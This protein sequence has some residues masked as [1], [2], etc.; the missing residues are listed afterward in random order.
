MTRSGEAGEDCPNWVR[1]RYVNWD[2]WDDRDGEESRK[3]RGG[4][5]GMK[6]V[7]DKAYPASRFQPNIRIL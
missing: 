1:W 4:E 5:D 6:E 3:K 7:D 2:E